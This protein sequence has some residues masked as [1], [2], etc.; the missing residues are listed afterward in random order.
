MCKQ[1]VIGGYRG[2]EKELI[3]ESLFKGYKDPMMQ[4]ELLDRSAGKCYA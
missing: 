3:G 2:W 1:R 4:D